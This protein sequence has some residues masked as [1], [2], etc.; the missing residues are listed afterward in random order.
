VKKFPVTDE[1]L[2][3]VGRCAIFCFRPAGDT[4]R[5]KNC[6]LLSVPPGQTYT[7]TCVIFCILPIPVWILDWLNL[8]ITPSF[9]VWRFTF[10][11]VKP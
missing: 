10:H 4:V 9:V 6:E 7:K 8:N 1:A 3:V 11:S 2:K 5:S